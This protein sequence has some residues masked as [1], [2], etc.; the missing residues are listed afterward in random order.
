M[1]R[2]G[3][4]TPATRAAVIERLLQVGYAERR[5]KA[6]APTPKGEF[7]I[8]VCPEELRSA[9]L[10]ARLEAALREVEGGRLAPEKVREEAAALAA[11]VV[12]HAA[13]LARLMQAP[14]AGRALVAAPGPAGG[15]P[16][17]RTWRR[18]H[19]EGD[20]GEFGRHFPA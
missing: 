8:G 20:R 5:G 4:G 7:L 12:R 13:H 3:L 15:S 10:T 9:E 18:H 14:G 6:L 17:T 19:A 16:P 2:A 11:R 1:E